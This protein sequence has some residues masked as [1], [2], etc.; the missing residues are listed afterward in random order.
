MREFHDSIELIIL[1]EM[2]LGVNVTQIA[3]HFPLLL[4]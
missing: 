2:P 4:E 1:E 3:Y